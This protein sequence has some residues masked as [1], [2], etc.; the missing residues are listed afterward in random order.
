MS[1]LSR[2]GYSVNKKTLRREVLQE[3]RKALTMTPFVEREEYAHLAQP[4]KMYQE[5]DQRLYMPRF[6]ACKNIGPPDIDKVNTKKFEKCPRLKFCGK[7]RPYQVPV[8][9]ATLKSLETF[10]GG[11]ISIGCGAG[12]TSIS[13]NIACI[14]GIPTGV[15]CN[16]TSMM[17][18]WHERIR[19][20]A[21]EAK[22]GIVQRDRT[23]IEGMDFVIMSVKTL[24]MRDYPKDTFERL[25][26][27]IWDEVHL[28]P[29]TLFSLAFPKLTTKYSIGLS[30]T[31]Y[32]KDK[33]EEVIYNFIGPICYFKKRDRDTSIEARCVSLMMEDI[34]TPT[35]K[36]GK[37][38]YTSMA[39]ATVKRPE[40]TEFL[41]KL[42]CELTLDDRTILVLGEYVDQLK[43]LKK[44]LL[45][46]RP[47]KP[48]EYEP[49]MAWLMGG[50]ARLGENSNIK[51]LP[52]DLQRYIVEK[53]LVLREA[54]VG[55]YIGAMKCDQ[56]KI[57]EGM[58]VILGTYK[59]ASVGMD[60]S[61]LNTLLFASP[62]KDIEQSVG[63]ILR[64]QSGEGINP[65]IIDIIDNHGVFQ[66]QGRVRKKFYKEYG[67]TIIHEKMLTDGTILSKR[68]I[69]SAEDTGT[70]DS[71]PIDCAN[72]GPDDGVCE[73]ESPKECMFD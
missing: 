45:A 64:K 14:K 33:C 73:E 43:M 3:Y 62:R 57:S 29:T 1:I 34:E 50:H 40:R 4:I 54:T 23:E 27:V 19:Q 58:D 42:L 69:K 12:K 10:G 52:K 17:K 39:V 51:R 30:A 61:S 46:M 49:K 44:S 56:R 24:A 25:G 67:Y 31:P 71:N 70:D 53:Y 28:Y 32:R 11:V 72:D 21:P 13:I 48:L 60:I 7:M 36:F 26:M 55:L 16:T 35:N 68:T 59:L 20:F 6:W 47:M 38:M 63:R 22:I 41:S 15:V 5:T 37:I 8:V 9:N 65:L 66:S 18:Q 2:R